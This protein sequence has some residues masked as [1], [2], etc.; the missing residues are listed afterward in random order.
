[1]ANP[2]SIAIVATGTLTNIALL[3]HNYAD[4]LPQIRYLAIMG[5]GVGMGNSTPFAEFNIWVCLL[6]KGEFLVAGLSSNC[7]VTQRLPT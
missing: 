2:G 6:T 5:G 3:V 4:L 7:S 1:M